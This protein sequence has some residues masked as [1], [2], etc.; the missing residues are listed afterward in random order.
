MKSRLWPGLLCGPTSTAWWAARG[1]NCSGPGRRRGCDD[2]RQF[3][4]PQA[5]PENPDLISRTVLS[6]GLD[7]GT[8]LRFCPLI[9]PMWMW[10]AT[11]GLSFR[12]TRPRR[13]SGLPRPRPKS[14]GLWPLP[15][16][17]MKASVEEMRAQV[18]KS[19]AQV[20]LAMADALRQGKLGVMD[21]Y[22]LQNLCRIP[23]C[24]KHFPG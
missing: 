13:T 22:N 7:A 8:P 3:R 4:N 11:S 5:R 23:G 2:R 14:A 21:Y 6:K 17:E 16:Q 18:V 12:P 1:R 20:P 19:E 10:A 24:V 15:E 9:L